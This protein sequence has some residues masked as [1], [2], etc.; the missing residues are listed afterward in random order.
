MTVSSTM[1]PVAG[2]RRQESVEWCVGREAMDVGV[3][4]SKKEEARGPETRC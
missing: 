3:I 1:P 2:C 4:R